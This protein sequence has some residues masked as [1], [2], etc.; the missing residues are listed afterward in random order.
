MNEAVGIVLSCEHASREL[1]ERLCI[2]IPDAVLESHRGWDPGAARVGRAVAE[3]LGERLHEG[4]YTRLLVEQNR[5]LNSEELWSEY[6][7]GLSEED[8]RRVLD[9]VYLPYRDEL[10]S[11]LKRALGHFERVAHI[12]IHSFTEVWKGERREVDLGILFDPARAFEVEVAGMLM[13]GLRERLPGWEIRLNEPY[14]G[15]DDG[16][17]HWYRKRFAAERYAGIEIELKQSLLGDGADWRAAS[18]AL[19]RSIEA[20][21]V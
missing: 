16:L 20:L 17:N 1:P 15:T 3:G 6:S 4:R 11:S 14:L 7:R 10:E 8:K 9:E 2:P 18:E 21:Q 12:S 13:K 5:S 19:E